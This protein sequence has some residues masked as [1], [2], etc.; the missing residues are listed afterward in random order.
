[1]RKTVSNKFY[2]TTIA[3][4][5]TLSAVLY[6]DGSLTQA[7]NP[8]S[9]ARIPDWQ[10]DTSSRPTLYSIV[11]VNGELK[12][13]QNVTWYYNSQALT[14][15]ANH[16][17]NAVTGADAGT[18]FDT[19]K[20][21]ETGKP[22][23]PAVQLRKNLASA[24]NQDHDVISLSGKVEVGG[25]L[26]P[27]NISYPVRITTQSS[28]GYFG[29]ITGDSVISSDTSTDPGYTANMSAV[30]YNGMSQVQS[31][32]TKWYREGIDTTTPFRTV[33]ATNYTADTT[34]NASQVLDNVIIRVEY[35]ASSAAGSP[36]LYTAFWS[37]DDIRDPEELQIAHG[38]SNQN[39]ASLRVGES[40]G[41]YTWMGRRDDPTYVDTTYTEFKLKITGAN[42][43]RIPISI[44]KTNNYV[45]SKDTTSISEYIDITV[46]GSTTLPTSVT[47]TAAGRATIEYDFGE[48]AG[49]MVTGYIVAY[50]SNV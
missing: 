38:L 2:V 23:Q 8:E 28:S 47:T 1:M 25:A 37:V 49:G 39:N 19:T 3:D 36:L 34:I 15:D 24:N 4:N 42:N 6:V 27:F 48:E 17:S 32:Y 22:V 44:D 46:T 35:Y 45:I 12:T 10:T 40:V 9:G 18:F 33:S 7:Y 14:F 30:L 20:S 41:F 50:G 13:V 11:R 43:V 29:Y 21:V 31:F 26:M 5:Y 16:L